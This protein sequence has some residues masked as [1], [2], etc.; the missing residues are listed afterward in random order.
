[1]TG[2]NLNERVADLPNDS[3][4]E[5]PPG[6]TVTPSGHEKLVTVVSSPYTR[7]RTYGGENRWVSVDH[8]GPYDQLEFA[9]LRAR[10]ITDGTEEEI[11][12]AM[13]DGRIPC[14][15]SGGWTQDSFP[16]FVGEGRFVYLPEDEAVALAMGCLD[17]GGVLMDGLVVTGPTMF[18]GR[19]ERPDALGK[20]MEYLASRL[21]DDRGVR[22]SDSGVGTLTDFV[23]SQIRL[24]A[25][26]SSLQPY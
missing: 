15:Q 19:E 26:Q 14:Y 3:I 7:V 8:E 20:V 9:Y 16:G 23:G 13:R 22:L 17:S 11:L 1:M 5:L 6:F 12:K 21:I 18:Y 4:L 10:K 2:M 25:T 24:P